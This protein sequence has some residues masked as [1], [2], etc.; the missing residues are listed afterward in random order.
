MTKEIE[1]QTAFLKYIDKDQSW[2][3]ADKLL[4]QHIALPMYYE[5]DL[6]QVDYVSN[7]LNELI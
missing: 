6:D 1:Q 5:M 4:S 3:Y 7:A 2:P